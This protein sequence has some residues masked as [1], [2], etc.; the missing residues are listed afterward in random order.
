MSLTQPPS[1]PAMKDKFVHA[2]FMELD[3]EPFLIPSIRPFAD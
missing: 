2:R 1:R 3:P